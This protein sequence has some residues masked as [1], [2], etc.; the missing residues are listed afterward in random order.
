MMFY[1]INITLHFFW[2]QTAKDG[3]QRA[4]ARFDGM[5]ENPNTKDPYAMS[6]DARQNDTGSSIFSKE[7]SIISTL[8]IQINKQ[9]IKDII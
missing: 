8:N 2:E 6:Y 5:Q 7:P 1:K 3:K 4:Y 9:T